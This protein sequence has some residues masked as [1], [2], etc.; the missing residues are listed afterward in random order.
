MN[1]FNKFTIF[2]ISGI[3]LQITC[4]LGACIA[5]INNYAVHTILFE[6]LIIPNFLSYILIIIG[7]IGLLEI[8]LRKK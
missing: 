4:I 5:A 7:F 8:N 3:L 6:K 2:F 1:N